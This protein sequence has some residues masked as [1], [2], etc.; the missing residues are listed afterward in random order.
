MTALRHLPLFLLIMGLFSVSMLVPALYALALDEFHEARSFF[1]A[2][3]IGLILVCLVGI[4]ISNRPHKPTSMSQLQA[5]LSVFLF[6]PVILAMPFY[7]SI[8]T[9]TFLSAYFEMVSCLSTTGLTLFDPHRLSDA[10]HLWRS[11]VAWIGGGIMWVAAAAILAPLSLGGFEVTSRGQPGQPGNLSGQGHEQADTVLRLWR[12]INTLVPVYA[13]L[14]LALAVML[15][16]L[17]HSVLDS[18][19][20][21][22]STLSTSGITNGGPVLDIGIADEAVICCFLLFGLS[23]LTFAGDTKAV[24][25]K[26]IWADAEFRMGMLIVLAVPM[27]LLVRHWL[28]ALEIGEQ[29]DWLAALRG[30]WGAFFTA[31]SF[32][33]T[34]G[35][36]SADWGTAQSWSGLATPD[37]ILIGL[38]VLGGGVATT[39]GGVKLLRV[40][41]LYLNGRR[42]IEKLVHPSQMIVP[43][44][45]DARI[46]REGAFI[47]WVFFMMFA[48]SITGVCLVLGLA[49]IVF[50]PAMVL[51]VATLTNTGPLLNITTSGEIDLIGLAASAKMILSL[52]MVLGRLEILAIIVVLSAGIWRD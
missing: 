40:V 46:G 33:T 24:Q 45:S 27:V 25:R 16:F 44:R 32:L 43:G 4:A 9:T 12:C 18:T 34:T 6:L 31:M 39:A 8:Q 5:L 15:I 3:V 1:Y 28:G 23:R 36:V 29:Q 51:S 50:E 10:E 48:L 35:F 14:T 30:F 26:G 20:L 7:E 17:G 38:A 42:E 21:A 52:A 47:A 19:I 49:G 41:A 22:M 2:A 37:L 13:G 11:Q